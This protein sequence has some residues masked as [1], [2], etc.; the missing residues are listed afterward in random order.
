MRA[1]MG[2]LKT[3]FTAGMAL[4]AALDSLATADITWAPALDGDGERLAGLISVPGIVTAYR[5]GL[6]RDVRR[7]AGLATGICCWRCASGRIRHS[8]AARCATWRCRPA[9]CSFRG[10]EARW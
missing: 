8:S 10:G 9:R 1:A 6:E 3:R 5:A 4:D 7:A 2:A